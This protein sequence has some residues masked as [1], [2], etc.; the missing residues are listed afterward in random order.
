MMEADVNIFLR[1]FSN[2]EYWKISPY[3]ST[4]LPVVF[5][6]AMVSLVSFEMDDIKILMQDWL[7][8]IQHI[9]LG[10]GF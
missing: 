2:S 8:Q 9:Q 3:L 6:S 10:T 1:R 5:F 7:Y 4:I